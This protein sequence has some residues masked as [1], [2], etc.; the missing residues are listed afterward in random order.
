MTRGSTKGIL[1]SFPFSTFPTGFE[2]TWP[3]QS[4]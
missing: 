3:N 4:T 1:L 2:Q